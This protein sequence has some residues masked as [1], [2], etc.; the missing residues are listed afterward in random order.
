[1]T[2]TLPS[3]I[4]TGPPPHTLREGIDWTVTV[5]A[6]ERRRNYRGGPVLTLAVCTVEA[7]GYRKQSTLRDPV[8][9]MR[10]ADWLIRQGYADDQDWPA[11]IVANRDR[12]YGRPGRKF[13]V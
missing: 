9:C 2:Y 13:A 5:T 8:A 6:I 12:Y 1:M 3:P 4:T 7:P 10:V 11:E